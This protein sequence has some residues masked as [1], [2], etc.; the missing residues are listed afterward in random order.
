MV[1]DSCTA[2]SDPAHSGEEAE[3]CSQRC[4]RA[5]V[6]TSQSWLISSKATRLSICSVHTTASAELSHTV[7]ASASLGIPS[8]ARHG[9][10]RMCPRARST[11]PRSTGETPLRLVH[12]GSSEGEVRRVE[13]HVLLVS[14]RERNKRAEIKIAEASGMGSVTLAQVGAPF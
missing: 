4:W 8:A 14:I 10:R 7:K 11:L 13:A 3:W 2:R 5:R 1:T 12:D 9:C 6:Y